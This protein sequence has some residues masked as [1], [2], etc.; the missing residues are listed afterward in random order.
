M[1]A[2][3]CVSSAFFSFLALSKVTLI[4]GAIFGLEEDGD[5]GLKKFDFSFPT[6]CFE[7]AAVVSSEPALY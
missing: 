2:N 4:A 5:G 3:N 7:F 1:L 6:F